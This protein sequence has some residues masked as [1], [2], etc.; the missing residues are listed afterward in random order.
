MEEA[1]IASSKIAFYYTMKTLQ[2][3]LLEIN[4]KYLDFSRKDA[5]L[6]HHCYIPGIPPL[7]IF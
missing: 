3:E 2:E 7:P 6:L 1:G 5:E 4:G